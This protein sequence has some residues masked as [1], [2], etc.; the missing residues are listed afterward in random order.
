MEEAPFDQVMHDDTATQRPEPS[1]SGSDTDPDAG[2]SAPDVGPGA[3]DNRVP[4]SEDPAPGVDP[5]GPDTAHQVPAGVD[6]AV[7]EVVGQVTAALEVVEHARGLLYGFHRLTGRADNDLAEALDALDSLGHH[8]L[9]R[10]VREDLFGRNVLAYRWTF[11]VVEDY[12]DNYWSRWRYWEQTI[13]DELVDGRRHVYEAQMKER[14][15]THGRRHHEARP[16][17]TP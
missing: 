1:P 14:H 6:D 16:P 11:Q 15:R 5:D 13:R 3:P 4:D 2:R 12:D 10:R 8:E 9:A 17:D 7:V